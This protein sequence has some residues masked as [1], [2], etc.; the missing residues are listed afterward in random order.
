MR[1]SLDSF[2][3]DVTKIKE[4]LKHNSFPPFL[5]DKITK[6]YLDKVHSN[7]DESN[8]ESDKIRFYKLPYIG[9]YSE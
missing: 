1:E 6:F 8:L 4:T 2:H 3:S 7:G 5:I 9:K